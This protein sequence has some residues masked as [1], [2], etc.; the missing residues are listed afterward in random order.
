MYQVG[1]RLA[2]LDIKSFWA[3]PER[4]KASFCQE[5]L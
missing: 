4:G 1:G 3:R 2:T 5:V